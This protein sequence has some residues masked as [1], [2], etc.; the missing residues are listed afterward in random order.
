MTSDHDSKQPKD[1]DTLIERGA[2]WFI[3]KDR[4]L[5]ESERKDLKELLQNDPALS[6]EIERFE[7]TK[8]LVG[9][10]PKDF[11]DEMLT[12]AN[13]RPR[14]ILLWPIAAGIAAIVA[15]GISFVVF[16]LS[17]ERFTGRYAQE[18][19]NSEKAPK[20]HLLP[21]GS[22][23]RLNV[24]S[25]LEV[26]YRENERRINLNKGE[27]LFEVTPDP[28]RSFIVDVEGVEIRAV[29]TAFNVKLSQ[30]IDVIVTHGIVEI[31]SP[32]KMAKS[33]RPESTNDVFLSSD[34]FV[35]VGQ[36]AQ[37]LPY[38]TGGSVV[39]QVFDI[40]DEELETELDWRKS[41]LALSGES[42][43]EMAV[44]FEQKTGYRL[45]ILDPELKKLRI[46]GRFPSNDVFGFL[47]ILKAGYGI[48][49]QEEEDGVIILGGRPESN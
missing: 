44:S 14:G 39:I 34:K 48:E 25:E 40:A 6:K 45:V 5:K 3:K 16:D 19:V 1:K 15:L 9:K 38:T 36:R 30:Q 20:T 28:K 43:V 29:G 26:V 31:G 13:P 41:L 42:L 22:L 33:S 37:V 11:V 4:G 10:L 12:K 2:D 21:D 8:A 17:N 18:S 23:I 32:N 35:A 27:A 7:D 47:R 46:G 49:W 24:D